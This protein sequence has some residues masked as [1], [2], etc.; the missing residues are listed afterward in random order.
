[1]AGEIVVRQLGG[2]W[3][4]EVKGTRFPCAIGRGG[5]SKAKCEGDGATPLGSFALREV[6]FKPDR[7]IVPRTAL[8]MRPLSPTMGWCD[9]PLDPAYNRLVSW[10]WRSSAE[11]LWRQDGLYDVIVPLGYNDSPVRPGAG[12]AIFLHVARTGLLP[13]E[14]CV[15]LGRS[16]LLR[17]LPCLNSTW[18][19]TVSA[20]KG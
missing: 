15:A 20:E 5:V 2:V 3:C 16:D 6:L 18:R 1:M 19:L 9:A 7:G 11:R 8:P 10:P 17:L 14:G 12:S 4:A 13:T